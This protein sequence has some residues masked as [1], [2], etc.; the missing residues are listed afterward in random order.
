MLVYAFRNSEYMSLYTLEAV[1]LMT[2]PTSIGRSSYKVPEEV[3]LTDLSGQVVMLHLGSSDY[4]S[5]NEV[6][7]IYFRLLLE[8]ADPQEIV[9]QVSQ[10][11]DVEASQ[12]MLDLV[13]FEHRLISRG[14]LL[15]NPHDS[16]HRSP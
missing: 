9:R 6:G 3:V 4:L 16:A 15:R 13:D 5:L 8:G 12:V 7:S 11:F 2:I 10:E 1:L 14:L